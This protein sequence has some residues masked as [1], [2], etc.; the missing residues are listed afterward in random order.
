MPSLFL[1]SFFLVLFLLFFFIFVTS[2]LVTWDEIEGQSGGVGHEM[3]ETVCQ[4]ELGRSWE[5]LLRVVSFAPLV[6]LHHLGSQVIGQRSDY[7]WSQSQSGAPFQ[8]AQI[9]P[10]CR[11]AVNY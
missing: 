9:L 5:V 11:Q 2:S 1:L 10:A 8:L 3:A 7:R 4:W 6:V